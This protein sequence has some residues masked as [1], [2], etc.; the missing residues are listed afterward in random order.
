MMSANLSDISILNIKGSAYRCIISFISKNEAV[1]L[2]QNADVTEKVEHDKRSKIH[3]YIKKTDKEI[4]T[5]GNIEIEQNLNR[6]KTPI[7]LEDV[8][9]KKVLVYNKISFG[10]KTYKYFISYLY[11]NHK[12]KPLHIILP[13]TTAYIKS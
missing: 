7:L 11:D 13:K 12:V 8:D 10:E 6:H 4:L 3:F 2:L 9:I 1:N 5:F